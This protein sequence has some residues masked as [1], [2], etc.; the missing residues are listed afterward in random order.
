MGPLLSKGQA[1]WTGGIASCFG[2]TRT[3]LMYCAEARA[4]DFTM[5]KLQSSP[6]SRRWRVL[7][8]WPTAFI[9]K[10]TMMTTICG[11]SLRTW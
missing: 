1:G 8:G 6:Q 4:Q 10:Q 5:K 11:R 3:K 2:F 9:F 7:N